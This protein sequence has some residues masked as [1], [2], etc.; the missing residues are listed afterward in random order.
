M[1]GDAFIGLVS[2]CLCACVSV[3]R[4]ILVWEFDIPVPLK[5]IAE[6]DMHCIPSVTVHPSQTALAGQSMDNKIVVYSCGDK[7]RQLKKKTFTGHNN[8]G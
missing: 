5:Y 8:S 1:Y 7:V 6:P 2:V 4:K 3:C